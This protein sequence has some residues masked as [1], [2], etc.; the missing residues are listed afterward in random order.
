MWTIA[1]QPTALW[2][3]NWNT[4]VYA[5]VYNY[6]KRA[7]DD[8]GMPVLALYNIPQRDCGGYSDGGADVAAYPGWVEQV[9]PAIGSEQAAV[10]LEPD[11]LAQIDQPGCLSDVAKAKR[12]AL[13]QLAVSTLKNRAANTTVY[14]DAGHSNWISANNMAQYLKNAGIAAADGFA[15]NVSNFTSIESNVAYG[16]QLSA[17]AGGKHFVV[18][19]SRNGSGP[20]SDGQWCNPAGRTLGASPQG[21]SSGLVDAF[22][23]IKRP[24]ES[25][26]S[27]RGGPGAG[28]FWPPFAYELTLRPNR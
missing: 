26:G 25:D 8:G 21:F 20:A 28:I 3:G 23:W 16:N 7:Q 10:I 5:D 18:D 12:Y 6:V 13:L 17:L 11:A 9:A 15:L 1:T 14:L 24:G 27:C 2:V 22:L 4:N 19:T